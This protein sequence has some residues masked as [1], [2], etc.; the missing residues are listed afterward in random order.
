MSESAFASAS[1]LGAAYRR[2]ELSPVEATRAQL[3][4]IEALEPRLHAY[5]TVLSDAATADALAAERELGRGE[6]R[7][8]LHGIPIAVKDLCDTKG[9]RT[10]RGMRVYSDHVP[11]RDAAVVERLRAAGAVLLGKLA[12]TEGALIEH[13][14]DVAAPLNPWD[15]SRW[16]GVSSSGS[17]VA[18]AAGLCTAALG[19]DTGG[20]IR[21]PSACC[22]VVGIKPTYGRVPLSGVFP[23]ATSLDH[24]GPMARSVADAAAL[25][26]VLAGHDSGDPGSLRAPVPDYTAEL[27]EGVSG[28][29]I[30]YD[31]AY[32]SEQ[33]DGEVSE[34]VRTA[35]DVLAGLGARIVEIQM[36]P[37]AELAR[38]WMP[39][40][41]VE[42]ALAH[43]AT[44]PS[45]A[46]DYGP[47]LRRLLEGAASIPALE[48]ARA[49][50]LRREFRG[51]LRDRFCD[52]D[53]I[54]CPSMAMA[55]PPLELMKAVGD[56]DTSP[57]M[58]FTAP[59][60]FS[61]SPTLSLPC[62]FS[63]EGL[64]L[65]LQLVARHL[66]EALLCRAGHAYERATDWH[67]AHPQI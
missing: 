4:R 12:M 22:G 15:E 24:V 27:G 34:A 36:P 29:R 49:D 54:A 46:D 47:A 61:G 7:G 63:G 2:G 35:L 31:A 56:G 44:F 50:A 62:G 5:F 64:P 59:F 51:R 42:A 48:L 37:V 38:S 58:K 41:A 6:D 23:L 1:E 57:F 21:F 18:V 39:V 10:T 65:S 53:L 13:H 14:P 43:E 52:V 55:A 32:A 16:T 17:G 67:S 66:E 40:C 19:S 9:V 3:A 25:L 30:G 20:S 26:G 33:T 45:R 11:E 28:L 8:P 60:D